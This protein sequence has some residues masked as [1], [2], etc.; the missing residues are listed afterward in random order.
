MRVAA[1]ARE[2]ERRALEAARVSERQS[3]LRDEASAA[4]RANASVTMKWADIKERSLPQE[5]ADELEAQ[6]KACAAI[7]DQR[8]ALAAGLAAELKQKDEEY[9]KGL[10]AQRADIDALLQ[11]MSTQFAELRE[12]YGDELQAIDSAF[13]RE[14][15]ELMA[16]NKAE[17]DSLFDGRRRQEQ[18]FADEKIAR[19]ERFA[20]EIYAMQ[21]ADLENFQ[22]LKVKLETDVAILEQQ[23]E[24]MKFV[25][26]LNTEK[27]EY[28]YRVLTERDNE[29]KAAL[30][31][32][33][34]RLARLRTSLAK[35]QQDYEAADHKFKLRN[36]ALTKEYQRATRS[37][38]ELQAKFRHFEAAEQAKYAS[39]SNLHEGEVQAMSIR[40]TTADKV[41]TE[42]LLGLPWAPPTAAQASAAATGTT[43]A[44]PLAQSHAGGRGLEEGG[45]ALPGHQQ[46]QQ[47]QHH[48]TA[49]AVLGSADGP[50][51]LAESATVDAKKLQPLLRLL[52][53]ECSPFIG[54]SATRE[55]CAKLDAERKRDQAQ[56]LRADSL[57]RAAGAESAAAVASLVGHF[58]NALACASSGKGDAGG[59]EE[60]S[61]SV[62]FSL[63]LTRPDGL[64]VLPPGFSTLRTLKSWIE[65]R[66]LELE[67]G[68]GAEG[69]ATGAGA[70]NGSINLDD[71]LARIADAQSREGVEGSQ[72]L[73][74]GGG[75]DKHDLARWQRMADEAVPPARVRVWKALERGMQKYQKVLQKR[76]SLLSE[77][78]QLASA[79]AELR[80]LL[81]SYMARPAASELLVGPSVTVQVGGQTRDVLN[82]A[83]ATMASGGGVS[84][85]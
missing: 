54:D 52:V 79:N 75:R 20:T 29:N 8:D 69:S 27:L 26:L 44:A 36:E 28:N 10:A 84:R 74:G 77:C 16:A 4:A 67:A 23:L 30:A 64:P 33:K 41:I 37:Y 47:L 58:E 55:A 48:L 82:I 50:S 59:E 17:V 14:R 56:V 72:T 61:S 46:Q 81:E 22:K 42:Q 63:V 53:A 24:H 18:R 13:E 60:D 1:D 32:Q 11:R 78:D 7:M 73:R 68:L 25:Y 3:R 15:E 85:R 51:V 39:I 34:A 38:R 66:K 40:L 6:R 70:T 71:T 31:A 80:Q 62:V 21:A 5:L 45:G 12:M 57:L 43:A 49:D 35:V 2:Q 19:E 83:A 9:L 76:A 65:S